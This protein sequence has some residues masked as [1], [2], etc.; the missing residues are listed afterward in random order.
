MLTTCKQIVFR[1]WMD[2]LNSETWPLCKCAEGFLV[3]V[4]GEAN[5]L[6]AEAEL[7]VK[8]EGATEP[9]LARPCCRQVDQQLIAGLQDCV[10]GAIGGRE[11][12]IIRR[13]THTKLH[14][15]VANI[16]VV[17]ISCA[18]NFLASSPGRIILGG[19][20]AWGRGLDAWYCI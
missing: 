20:P 4:I 13:C 15:F 18:H 3:T 2:T 6:R 7:G 9:T 10:A 5:H 12:N 14:D 1:R 16:F 11:I 8:L 19:R 17:E